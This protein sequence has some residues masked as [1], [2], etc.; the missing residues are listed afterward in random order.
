VITGVFV[1]GS[2]CEPTCMLPQQF[3]VTVNSQ[4]Q[5]AVYFKKERVYEPRKIN[6]FTNIILCDELERY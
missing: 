1:R 5:G 4:M 6:I 2:K 3:C